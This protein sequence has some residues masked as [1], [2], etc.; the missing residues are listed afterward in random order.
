MKYTS[1]L[2]SGTNIPS[3]SI[4][5]H[6]AP[7]LSHQTHQYSPTYTNIFHLNTITSHQAPT[8]SIKHGYSP[9]LTNIYHYLSNSPIL[10]H[11]IPKF[12]SKHHH[13]PWGINILHQTLLFLIR[14]QHYPSNTPTFSFQVW[15]FCFKHH[16]APIFFIK[17]LQFTSSH[18]QPSNSIPTFYIKPQYLQLHTNMLHQNMIS[19]HQLS[20]FSTKHTSNH[21]QMS[22]SQHKTLLIPIR[23]WHSP[24]KI[25]MVLNKW[26][27]TSILQTNYYPTKNFLLLNDIS[28]KQ[29]PIFFIKY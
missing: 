27:H 20:I 7:I 11:H 16:Q 29:T 14:H 24:V 9:S 13:Y 23:H 5:S 10:S 25:P 21:Q 28:I 18:V 8:L 6:Q 26:Q 2:L 4:T 17:P 22:N 3:N 15:A 1:Y 12:S 19:S